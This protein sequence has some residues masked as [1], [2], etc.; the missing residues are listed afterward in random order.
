MGAGRQSISLPTPPGQHGALEQ[1]HTFLY[2]QP[3]VLLLLSCK[4]SCSVLEHMHL[5]LHSLSMVKYTDY[6]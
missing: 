6:F 5:S 1:P 3:A 4:N 2:K